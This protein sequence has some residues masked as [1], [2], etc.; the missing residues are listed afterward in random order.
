MKQ[1]PHPIID[2]APGEAATS[3]NEE[4]KQTLLKAAIQA[5]DS[6][7]APF[8]NFKVGAAVLAGGRVFTGC[9]V[10]NASYG[11]TMCAERVAIFKAISA[12][13]A[14]IQALAVVAKYPKPV[15]PCGMCRQVMAE[16]ADDI[17]V[18]MGNLEGETAVER[19]SS[20]LPHMFKLEG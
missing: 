12:G 9:N 19:S 20:L 7:Y 8:S 2:P 13:H 17:P 18:V 6:A 4:L 11:A 15:P 1:V 5:R 14:D 10:E 3:L 16:F